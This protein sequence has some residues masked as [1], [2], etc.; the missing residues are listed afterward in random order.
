MGFIG[1]P[2]LQ[3]G[4]GLFSQDTFTGDGSTTT[5]DMT[6]AAPD[7]GDNDIQVFV[8]NVRQQAGSTAAY[9]LGFDGSSEFKRITF[10]TAPTSGQEIVVLNPGTKN[11]QQI[12]SISDNTVTA[13]KLQSNAVTTAKI[14]DSNV[15]TAKIAADAIDATKLA[16]DAISE[17]HLDN[18]AI[19]GNTELSAT[20]ADDDVLLIFDTSSSTIK[21]IQSSNVGITPP[22]FTSVSPSNLLTGDGTG[23]HT[24]VITGTKF[25]ATATF[26]LRTNGGTDITMDSVTRNSATQLTGVVAK[27]TSNLTNSNEP[28]DII[29]TNGNGLSVTAENA[30]NIDASP[31]FVTAAGS[32]GSFAGGSAHRIEVNATDPDSAGNVT[33]ELQ[34]GSLPTGMAL[35]VEGGNG[36]TA[37]ISGTATNPGANTTSNFVLRAV[38]AASNTTS[39]SFSITIT[40]T[41]SVTSFTSSGTFAVPSGTTVL[42]SVLVVAGGASGG[43]STAN[44]GGCGGGAGGGGA[45]GLIFMPSYPVSTGTITVTVGCGGVHP[46]SANNNGVNGQDSVFGAST[47][48]GFSPTSSVLTAK[49][50][51]YG[52]L[53][54]TGGGQPG[55]AGGSGGGGG[56]GQGGTGGTG[57]QPTQP[58]NSGAY[59]FG[60]P[61][62]RGGRCGSYDHNNGGGGGGGAGAAAANWYPTAP[63]SAGHVGSP[64]GIG[65][66]YTIADGTTP[67]YYAG[68]GGGAAGMSQIAFGGLGG[69]G[70]SNPADNPGPGTTGTQGYSTLGAPYPGSTPNDEA[71]SGDANKGGGG[72]G[73]GDNYGPTDVGKAGDGGKGIVIVRY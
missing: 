17:E 61:G 62:G 35:T 22:T 39:R 16:D 42:D 73:M 67:V 63:C 19:T 69:G 51:G 50:G 65:K 30:I 43:T 27:N 53:G 48:P 36:G 58:G 34:S 71:M 66:A 18:T 7:G 4:I 29:I 57:N 47:D 52:G 64:G 15:T 41:F 40:R 12:T 31:T 8:D 6:N 32:L 14:T 20:A 72:A 60:N 10:T 3:Q 24:I 28:F 44:G 59:G 23:N 49:G 2:P 37:V 5:F 25:D 45:G 26:K 56:N 9:T 70:G 68:G 55:G 54:N 11:A 38:D 21:K 13:A 46:N 1:N 33:F